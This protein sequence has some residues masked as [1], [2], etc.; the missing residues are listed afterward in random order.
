MHLSSKASAVALALLVTAQSSSAQPIPF[1]A[2]NLLEA[3]LRADGIDTAPGSG[4]RQALNCIRGSARN[5]WAYHCVAALVDTARGGRSAAVEIMIFSDG[6]DFASRD[7]QIKALVTRLNGRWSLDYASEIVI[8]GEGQKI[9][10]KG[11]CHQSRGQE[12]SPAYC[13]LPVARNVLI[14][15]QAAPA[16]A[17]SDVVTTSEN[18]G[19]DSFDDMA[20]AGTLASLG[21]IAVVKARHGT[22]R[23]NNASDSLIR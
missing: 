10:L 17:S 16:E 19:S 11:A 5:D 3:Q 6:Y 7:A 21:A 9:T 2:P 23:I 15:S 22:D 13:L 12:N 18:G 20:H 14:F 8:N 4:E 1:I